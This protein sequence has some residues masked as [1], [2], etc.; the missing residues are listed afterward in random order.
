MKT[1]E[2]SDAGRAPGRPKDDAKRSAILQAARCIFVEEGPAGATIEAIA[3]AAGVSRVTIYSH[4]EN[5]DRLMAAVL[6]EETRAFG[7][8]SLALEG[9][10]LSREEVRDALIAFGS[11]LL[12]FVEQPHVV[13][14][15]RMMIGQA[16]AMSGA[17]KVFFE[18]GP[19]RMH[20]RLARLIASAKAAGALQTDDPEEDADF[21]IG[22]WR[23]LHHIELQLNAGP[24]RS[25]KSRYERVRRAVDLYLAAREQ[26]K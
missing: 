22:M 4:F 3:E 13:R 9:G 26:K 6:E 25:R 12:D 21:L 14:S 19:L 10:T 24:P 5:K 16:N 20:R 2:K 23:G 17:T 11:S 7:S 18:N 1:L 15:S 8:L